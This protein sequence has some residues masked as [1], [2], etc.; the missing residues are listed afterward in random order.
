M[1]SSGG[2]RGHRRQARG[3]T[4]LLDQK[5][6]E[7]LRTLPDWSAKDEETLVGEFLGGRAEEWAEALCDAEVPPGEVSV[8][9]DAHQWKLQLVPASGL[10]LTISL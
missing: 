5:N 2:G 10:G 1:D 6:M 3:F 9:I 8:E 7:R 4:F